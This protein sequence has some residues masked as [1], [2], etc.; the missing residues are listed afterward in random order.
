M[1]KAP[2]TPLH[3]ERTAAENTTPNNADLKTGPLSPLTPRQVQVLQSVEIWI[4]AH[5]WPPYLSDLCGMLGTTSK[6]VVAEHLKAIERKGYVEVTGEH[7]GIRVLIPSSRAVIKADRPT[8][9]KAPLLPNASIAE[10]E[11]ELR[12]RGVMKKA[13]GEK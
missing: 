12:R 9:K 5:G 8:V 6:S 13:M 3:G 4:D 11:A 7:R 1:H 2:I 10:I